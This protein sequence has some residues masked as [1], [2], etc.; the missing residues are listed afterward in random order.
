MNVNDRNLGMNQD[1]SRRDF[2]NG[3]AMAAG[4]LVVPKWA[5]AFEQDYAPERAADYYPP[6][7]TGMRGDHVGSFEAAHALRDR[8]SIDVSAASHTGETYDLVV[9]G[10][11]QERRALSIVAPSRRALLRQGHV[12]RRPPSGE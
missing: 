7:L 12:G 4:T 6:T 1:I 5:A 8:K 9:V 10:G 11:Q 3:V 2:M